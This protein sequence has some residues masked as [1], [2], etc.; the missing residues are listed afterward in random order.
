MLRHLLSLG[1][2]LGEEEL[3]PGSVARW[4]GEDGKAGGIKAGD[5]GIS[6]LR[7]VGERDCRQGG[8]PPAYCWCTGGRALDPA[9]V[10]EMITAVLADFDDAMEPL[11][12]CQKLKLARVKD[13]TTKVQGERVMIEASVVVDVVPR[14]A[15]FMVR[16]FHPKTATNLL[17]ATATLT[18]LDI[19]RYTARCV[20]DAKDRPFC[21]C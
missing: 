17:N 9:L 13:A 19:Y 5:P 21:I 15:E 8:V 4:W 20:P 12:L 1:T 10:E 16:V 7:R 11:G 3:F 14:Q 2:G 6:L 18:R